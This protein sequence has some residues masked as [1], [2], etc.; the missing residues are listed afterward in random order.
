MITTGIVAK[1]WNVTPGTISG[2]PLYL[3]ERYG[4]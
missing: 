1:L 4:S 2:Q 3:T